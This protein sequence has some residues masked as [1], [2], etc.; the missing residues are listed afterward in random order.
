MYGGKT[1]LRGDV[2][3]ISYSNGVKVV[4]ERINSLKNLT[5]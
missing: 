3:T 2:D 4:Q 5:M 1:Q